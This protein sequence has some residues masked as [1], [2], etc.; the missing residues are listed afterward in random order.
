M[1][2]F[3][4]VLGEYRKAPEVTRSRLYLEMMEEVFG[5][6]EGTDLIDKNLNNF[7]PF[8]PLTGAA[9]GVSE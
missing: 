7:I 4:D 3:S 6:A 2:R 5:K 1:A 9:Q 8:K